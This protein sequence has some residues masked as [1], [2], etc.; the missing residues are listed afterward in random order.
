MKDS[1]KEGKKKPGTPLLSGISKIH[2]SPDTGRLSISIDNY[3]SKQIDISATI[4]EKSVKD[5][6]SLGLS[7][8][9]IFAETLPDPGK[10]QDL[11][12]LKQIKELEK[13]GTAALSDEAEIDRLV[14]PWVFR[15]IKLPEKNLVSITLQ[16]P[17]IKALKILCIQLEIE[18][19]NILIL[20]AQVIQALTGT[21]NYMDMAQ[22]QIY[23]AVGTQIEAVCDKIQ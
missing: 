17:Y 6:F 16:K 21:I 9:Q 19:K 5:V 2:I 15:A 22:Q 4:I 8:L 10:F 1:S 3:F 18:A 23:Q 20:S 12:I 7:A 11:D 13:I 14:T